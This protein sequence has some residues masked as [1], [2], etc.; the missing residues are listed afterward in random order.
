LDGK[1][2]DAYVA[3]PNRGAFGFNEEVEEF[4]LQT[5]PKVL[6]QAC[7]YKLFIAGRDCLPG[8]GKSP[9]RLW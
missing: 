5:L 6:E 8:Q 2:Y 9:M 4:V 7:G 3:Y 1:L